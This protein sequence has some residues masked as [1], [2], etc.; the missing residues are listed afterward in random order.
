MKLYSSIIILGLM[1]VIPSNKA[2]SEFYK[3]KDANGILRFTDNL[4]DLPENQRQDAHKYNEY[5][6]NKQDT[7]AD[8][9]EVLTQTEQQIKDTQKNDKALQIQMIGNKIAKIQE[10]LQ[11]EYNQL[12]AKKKAIEKRDQK[13]GPKNST[14]IEWLN[15]QAE[16]LNS[17]IR[18]YNEKKETYLEA[19][20]GYQRK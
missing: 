5:I 10:D 3:Y 16:Q 11:D 9:Q 13:P 15:R 19:I 1:M 18:A 20:K 6:S 7:Q 4:A 2:F 8:L 12:V 14:E 17:Q